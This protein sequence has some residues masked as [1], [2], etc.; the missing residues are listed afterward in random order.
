VVS[1][2]A[3]K[4]VSPFL[5]RLEGQDVQVSLV[6]RQVKQVGLQAVHSRVAACPYIP[7]GQF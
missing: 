4:Q 5:Y 7:T 2:Q 3:V 1:G 6:V